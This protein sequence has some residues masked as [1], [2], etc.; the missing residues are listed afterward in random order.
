ME[1]NDKAGPGGGKGSGKRGSGGDR[2]R[3]GGRA[4]RDRETGRRFVPGVYLFVWRTWG[5]EGLV[6]IRRYGWWVGD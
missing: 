4:L 1:A 5:A 6:G 2:G 3:G